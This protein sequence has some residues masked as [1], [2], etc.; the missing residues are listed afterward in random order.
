MACCFVIGISGV[1]CAGKTSLAQNLY[2]FLA[3]SKNVDYECTDIPIL[4]CLTNRLRGSHFRLG[5]VNVLHQDDYFLPEPCQQHIEAINHKNWELIT[6]LDMKKMCYDIEEILSQN[7][8]DG[9]DDDL[10]VGNRSNDVIN[11]LIIEGF[12]IFEDAYITDICNLKFH[13]HLPYEKCYARRKARVYDPVDVE[14]YFEMAVWPMYE[15]YFRD[16][17]RDRTDVKLLNGDLPPDRICT[18]V[19]TAII[20]VLN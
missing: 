1:S 4:A 16:R 17:I 7:L 11:I 19:L 15:K 10:M 6:A 3:Q 18:Y 5:T 9:D 8:E 12:T 2:N 20:N 13:L 14:G